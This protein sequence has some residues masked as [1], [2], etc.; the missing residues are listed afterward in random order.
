ML[1]FGIARALDESA[2]T[3]TGGLVGSPGWMSPERFRGHTGREA[4]IFAWGALVAYAA[5]GR[6]PFGTGDA[7]TL[8]YRV[9]NE[10]PD[11]G[12]L[13]VELAEPVTRALAKDATERPTAAEL[14]PMVVSG[15]GRAPTGDAADVAATIIERNWA[16]STPPGQ[17]HDGPRHAPAP[18]AATP[19]PNPSPPAPT[20]QPGPPASRPPGA[21]VPAPPAGHPPQWQHALPAQPQRPTSGA[22]LWV[23]VIAVVGVIVLIAGVGVGVGVAVLSD[24]EN[25]Q[26]SP[27]SSQDGSNAALAQLN[28]DGVVTLGVTENEP[29]AFVDKDGQ[30]TGR[31]PE[32]A[33][34]V[35]A[36]L[37]VTDVEVRTMNYE[38]L[39]SAMRSDEL[40][41]V[42]ADQTI[43]PERC[44][45]MAHSEPYA[46]LRTGFATQPEHVDELEQAAG[47]DELSFEEVAETDLDVGMVE[48]S[49]EQE[50]AVEEGIDYDRLEPGT[51]EKL[52]ERLAS[53]DIDVVA[54]DSVDLR[55]QQA[56]RDEFDIAGSFVRENNETAT[57]MVT[58]LA[59]PPENEELVDAVNEQISAFKE[60]GELQQ[61][62]G[63]F[64]MS[65]D[66]MPPDDLTIEDACSAT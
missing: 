57:P 36:E 15:Y 3:R 27:S 16:P 45:S 22:R 4:D 40:D 53:G 38:A 29:Y 8:M 9:L 11:L 56:Q 7:E 10:A 1:D 2:I 6:P 18:G 50:L 65:E 28:E 44:A 25:G 31:A 23:V 55:W 46:Q 63:D 21:G 64:G 61:I 43:T 39:Q 14:V 35:F 52:M 48:G 47:D 49:A 26:V 13:P 24:N 54:H 33:R 51:R 59:F 20:P 58:A 60:S 42:A 37:G 12:G 30:A 19:Q 34:A 62:T 17:E 66:E 41:V 32:L 5:T